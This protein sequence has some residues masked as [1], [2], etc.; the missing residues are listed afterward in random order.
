M[1][2]RAP[3]ARA[4]EGFTALDRKFGDLVLRL[5]VND[6]DLLAS[7]A[8]LVSRDRGRGHS[9][10]RLASYAGRTV[11]FDDDRR[12]LPRLPEWRERLL[13]SNLVATAEPWRPGDGARPLVLDASNRLYLWR[14]WRAEQRIAARLLDL[15]TA[16]RGERGPEKGME[17]PESSE[18]SDPPRANLGGV[19][20]SLF[21]AFDG[22]VDWQAAAAATAL[23]SPL[24]MISGGPGT[25]K[26]TTVVRLLA[27]MWQAEP[28]L[29]IALAAP[30]GKAAARLKEAIQG[31]LGA[32]E[33]KGLDLRARVARLDAKTLHRLLHYSPQGNRFRRDAERPLT[34][35]VLVV[36][37]ASMVDLLMMDAVLDA[38]PP[39]ARL[40]L[41][42]DRDQLSSVDT[43]FVFGDLCAAAGLGAG[44]PML[45][46]RQSRAYGR[47][48]PDFPTIEAPRHDAVGVDARQP[49]AARGLMDCGVELQVSYRFRERPGI[50]NLARALRRGDGQSAVAVLDDRAYPEVRRV[51]PPGQAED[52]VAPIVSAVDEFYDC[53]TPAQAL[54]ALEAFRIL[55]AT[56]KGRWG[57]ERLN[58][59]VETHLIQRGHLDP[60][61]LDF[62]FYHG[63]AVLV[64]ENDYGAQL[65][66][67][68]LGVCWEDP[69]DKSL[70]VHFAGADDGVGRRVALAKLP[71]HSTAWAMTVHKSQGSELD[72]V[73]LV[74]GEDDPSGRLSR[75]LLYTGVTRAR[76]EVDVV[77]PAS[78]IEAA[79]ARSSRRTT[80]LA[81]ALRGR[82]A[83]GADDAPEH[84]AGY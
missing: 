29:R 78:L 79:A 38:L 23:D 14:Y 13:A 21:P 73:L 51:D 68:D 48:E 11:S 72:H 55:A 70:W 37:E 20:R 45:S 84:V 32:L 33:E 22:E 41:L 76:R 6:R 53:Q 8:M 61:T 69:A 35:D 81:D 66:N 17:T 57:T 74:L 82:L 28:E 34:C 12:R 27:L 30:T 1:P 59:I 42:G 52:A 50:G 77:A 10:L 46:A 49:A 2:V 26:T 25:G 54:Q 19:W 5:A 15:R 67:G 36:D 75:E 31:Q 58:R 9:C 64:E 80:G 44:E 47:F 24:A 4:G 40:V 60:A 71:R 16:V 65:F 7:S 43:G 62:G 39:A 18:S 63:R 3:S 83:A 56:R